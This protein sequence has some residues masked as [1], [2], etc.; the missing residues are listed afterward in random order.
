MANKRQSL[1]NLYLDF[2]LRAQAFSPPSSWYVGLLSAAASRSSAGTE[3][4]TGAGYTGYARI[5]LVS[6]LANW[7]GTQGDGT[8]TASSGTNNYVSNNAAI[9]F[10]AS[11]AVAWTGIV[12][13][14]LYD[15][16]SAGNQR[17]F[18][19]IVDSGGSPI[20]RSFA[21]GE[22]CSFA[23]GTLRIYEA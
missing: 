14:A 11:L 15:A 17:L 12:G 20:T 2:L 4:S 19:V 5:E 8:T 13:F 3:I 9:Q 10:S 6:S 22:A 16:V 1:C 23:A 21:I 18:G 7:S